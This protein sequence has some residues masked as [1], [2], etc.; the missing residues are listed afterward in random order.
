MQ[1]FTEQAA[2]HREALDLV[3]AKYG[4][5]AQVLSHKTVRLGG[6]LGFFA[7]ECVEVT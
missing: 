1:Y 7:R 2:S 6:F 4:D 5:A 3:R